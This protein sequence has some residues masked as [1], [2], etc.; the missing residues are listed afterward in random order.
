MVGMSRAAMMVLALAWAPVA[1]G[2]EPEGHRGTAEVRGDVLVDV[3]LA[4]YAALNGEGQGTAQL[5]VQDR[6][7]SAA[8]RGRDV[9]RFRATVQLGERQLEI[10]L[11]APGRV[12]DPQEPS[13]AEQEASR[14]VAGGVALGGFW[15]GP[16]AQGEAWS[17]RRADILTWGTARVLLD[18]RELTDAARLELAA[19]APSDAGEE[20]AKSAGRLQLIVRGVPELSTI[21]VHFP[22]GVRVNVGASGTAEQG[23]KT[24]V[25]ARAAEGEDAGAPEVLRD[26]DELIPAEGPIPPEDLQRHVVVGTLPGP[27]RIEIETDEVQD[28]AEPGTGGSGEAQ[29]VGGSGSEQPSAQA[30]DDAGPGAAGGSGTPA[31]TGEQQRGAVGDDSVGQG[32]TGG[33]GTPAE[34]APQ[35]RM[36]AARAPTDADDAGARESLAGGAPPAEVGL[37]RGAGGSGSVQ[38]PQTRSAA[39]R[40]G[41]NVDGRIEGIAPSNA[42]SDVARVEVLQGAPTSVDGTTDVP[43]GVEPLN[44]APA[45]RG[46]RVLSPGV[47]PLTSDVQPSSTG[48][49]PP[50][51]VNDGVLPSTVTF[52]PG[53][54]GGNRF[55]PGVGGGPTAD[56]L[57]AQRQQEQAQGTVRPLGTLGDVPEMSAPIQPLNN[58]AASPLPQGIQPLNAQP[59]SP[60]R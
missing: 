29:D 39:P 37:P 36:D 14:E 35:E 7:D 26:A 13:G 44:A 56:Q 32:A 23:E 46:T 47:E 21:R 18:G 25:A 20:G 8:A 30:D 19:F 34:A 5:E 4:P 48:L 60:P 6:V 57:E 50:T 41:R 53:A 22:E 27:M 55:G 2:Q 16:M 9:A 24:Q 58:T 17:S 28:T 40:G 11:N 51:E 10:A 12:A 43:P 45:S 59:A 33:S 38:L 49:P 15:S 42:R 1:G 52:G 31:V 54:G 3:G